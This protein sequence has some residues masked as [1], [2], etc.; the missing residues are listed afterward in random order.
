MGRRHPHSCVLHPGQL[1]VRPHSPELFELLHR[2]PGVR[3][4]ELA[5]SWLFSSGS[6]KKLALFLLEVLGVK[7]QHAEPTGLDA[8]H[9]WRDPLDQ[10]TVEP[11]PGNLLEYTVG[12]RRVRLK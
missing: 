1:A 6:E 3:A 4:L 7:L 11:T 5:D 10:F 8:D 2:H 9:N 12:H